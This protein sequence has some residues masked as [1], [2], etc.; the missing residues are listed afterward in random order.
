MPHSDSERPGD[1][2]P[3]AGVIIRKAG[4]AGRITLAKPKALNALDHQMALAIEAALDAWSRDDGVDI[5][6]IDALGDK[7]FCAGGDIAALYRAGKA[8]DF[9]PARRFF[10]DEYRLNRT[11]ARYEK[12]YVALMDGIVMGGGVGLSA[13]GDRRIVTERSMVAMP[14]C[15]IGL[16][17]DVGGTLVLGEAPGRLGEYLGLTGYHMK[18]AD[19]ILAG[20]ADHCLPSSEIPRALARLEE[21]GDPGAID[22]MFET[23]DEGVLAGRREAIDRF[24]AEA[25]TAAILAALEADGS[26]FAVETARSIRR[27]SPLSAAVTLELV[28]AARADPTIETALAREYRYTFRAQEKGDFL[29]GTRAVVIDKDRSPQW[30][31]KRIEDLSRERVEAMLAPL[32]DD[33]LSF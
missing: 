16:I 25:D 5:V 20:F 22:A 19:A 8:G 32:G 33:E 7:A 3:A 28:R 30:P 10:A 15:G 17:P 14:E 27:G 24:F 9:L 12:P 11:I 31:E 2:A 18:A 13:H 29:E 4:R 6:V 21:T 26:D 1:A 23:P